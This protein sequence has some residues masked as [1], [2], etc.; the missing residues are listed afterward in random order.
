MEQKQIC[1]FLPYL[2][3]Y[4]KEAP[5][6]SQN[7]FVIHSEHTL[8]TG[9]KQQSQNI[10]FPQQ[11]EAAEGLVTSWKLRSSKPQICGIKTREEYSEIK[12]FL[13]SSGCFDID[14]PHYQV[15]SFHRH[16]SA[17]HEGA[18]HLHHSQGKKSFSETLQLLTLR[19]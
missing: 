10:W 17:L 2:V 14:L 1:L 8:K 15:T 18:S 5:A 6:A 4:R 7:I 11:A 19:T 3:R 16:R 9:N 13:F 12:R